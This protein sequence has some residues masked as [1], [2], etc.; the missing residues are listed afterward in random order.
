MTVLSKGAV[1]ALAFRATCAVMLVYTRGTRNH[2]RKRIAKRRSR[3]TT[4]AAQIKED[5][6]IEK[7]IFILMIKFYISSSKDIEQP[8]IL[9]WYIPDFTIIPDVGYISLSTPHLLRTLR[10]TNLSLTHLTSPF[11]SIRLFPFV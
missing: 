11:I 1:E 3:L 2:S 5:I 7:S 9:Y 4:R 6:A 8:T 10:P